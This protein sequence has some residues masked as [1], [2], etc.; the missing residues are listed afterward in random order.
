MSNTKKHANMAIFNVLKSVMDYKVKILNT[1]VDAGRRAE[2]ERPVIY[3][4]ISHLQHYV[5][6]NRYEPSEVREAEE[7]LV[8]YEQ[9]TVGINS[10]I[11]RGNAAKTELKCADKFY[12]IYN[13]VHK[14][15]TSG[16]R[17]QS[18]LARQS[19]IEIKLAALDKSMDACEI[20]MAPNVYDDSIREQAEHDMNNYRTTYAGL[21]EQLSEILQEL[22]ML[23]HVK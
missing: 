22:K 13:S 3:E 2:Q 7:A 15:S 5:M 10:K 18:L 6:N 11:D 17:I 20:N 4:H 14:L 9:Q 1:A 8:D 21:S 16:P 23:Q 12:S 19:E